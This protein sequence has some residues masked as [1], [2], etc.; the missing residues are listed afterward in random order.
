MNNELR[1]ISVLLKE[2][3]PLIDLALKTGPVWLFNQDYSR[4]FLR[5]SSKKYSFYR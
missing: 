4:G 5:S 1:D 3:H 2:V